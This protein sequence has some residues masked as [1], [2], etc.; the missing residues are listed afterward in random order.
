[1]STNLESHPTLDSGVMEKPGLTFVFLED[2]LTAATHCK[3]Q[4]WSKSVGSTFHEPSPTN[5]VW[6]VTETA[7]W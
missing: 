4:Y 3:S 7:V 2:L 5:N 6:Q 1:M